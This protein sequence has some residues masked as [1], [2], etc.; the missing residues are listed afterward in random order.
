MVPYLFGLIFRFGNIS[1]GWCKK[2]SRY[3]NI[4]ITS[5]QEGVLPMNSPPLPPPSTLLPPPS[6]G[7][8]GGREVEGGG[9]GGLTILGLGYRYN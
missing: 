5:A 8:G 3:Y 2:I 4:F 7:E 1:K 9:E 6:L